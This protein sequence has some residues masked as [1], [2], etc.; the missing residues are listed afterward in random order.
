MVPGSTSKHDRS[1]SFSSNVSVSNSN[2]GRLSRTVHS[3]ANSLMTGELP[4]QYHNAMTDIARRPQFQRRLFSVKNSRT[5]SELVKSFQRDDI[6]YHAVTQIPEE[7]LRDIPAQSSQFS[8]F[9]GFEARQHG[10]DLKQ[11]TSVSDAHPTRSVLRKDEEDISQRLDLLEIRKD[12]A[13]NEIKE[14]DQR[15]EHMQKMRKIVFDRVA[16]LEQEEFQLENTLRQ[17]RTR[18]AEM[19]EDDE[20]E[21]AE[22]KAIEEEDH[23]FVEVSTPTSTGSDE[24]SAGGLMSQSIYGKLKASTYKAKKPRSASR[25]KTMPTLQQFYAPGDEIRTIEAHTESV[26]SLDF[27]IPFGTMVS[28]ALDDTVKVWSLSQGEQI[29]SLE[30]HNASVKCLQVED[31]YVMTGSMDATLK[32]WDLNNIDNDEDLLVDSY[33]AHLGEITA[34]HFYDNTLVSGS[35]DKTIRQWDMQT[36]KCLQTL[37]VLWASAQSTT[38]VPLGDSKWRAKQTT[39]G[40]G[41]D[42]VGALQCYDA[43]LAS[44]TADGIVRLWDLRS[45]QVIRSL[46]GHTGAVTCLQFDDM[47]L[48]TGSQDRSI[49]IWDLRTGS[50]F[51]AF[52]YESPITS[53]HFDAR[54]VVSTNTENTVKIYDREVEK[55][56]SCGAGET[57][58]SASICEIA[59]YREGYLVEGRRDGKIGV[60]AC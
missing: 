17:V 28:A 7:V 27:D 1:E 19:G 52:A 25:R 45:G 9:Q 42:F 34:L 13:A 51:D 8:L 37:D 15:I 60:W 18:M 47:H 35:A 58:P 36:G 48:A 55:H 26:T 54:R 5:P 31:N 39:V 49:R 59:R 6:R 44:G 23:D 38:N 57:D 43:A 30:G 16:K 10:P 21:K 29:G 53:L 32:L 33:E 24:V 12:L 50:I 40:Q 14:I 11:I 56:W 46:I 4:A 22:S 20:P 2:L 3:T 41:G